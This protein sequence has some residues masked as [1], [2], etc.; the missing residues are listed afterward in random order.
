[1][2]QLLLLIT[3]GT[4]ICNAQEHFPGLP[5]PEI[6]N[7]IL[8]PKMEGYFWDTLSSIWNYDK[9]VYLYYTGNEITSSLAYDTINAL[10]LQRDTTG[11]DALGRVTLMQTQLFTGSWVNS[12]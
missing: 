12:F 4:G 7:H 5:D 1:M 9:T 11:F 3:F 6:Q 2:K 10:P 8:A